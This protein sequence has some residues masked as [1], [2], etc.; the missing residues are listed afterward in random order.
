V[1]AIFHILYKGRKVDIWL[2]QEIWICGFR[3]G[4]FM[5]FGKKLRL[6]VSDRI[7][8]FY[9]KLYHI[10]I[11]ILREGKWKENKIWTS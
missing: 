11:V 6:K 1:W 10:S 8:D 4:N 3:F 5:S 9:M 2:Q 7:V